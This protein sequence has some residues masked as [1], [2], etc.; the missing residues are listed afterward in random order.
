MRTILAA[1]VAVL[2]AMTPVMAQDD[3]YTEAEYV[4]AMRFAMG[5]A[6]YSV[7]HEVGHMMVGE[8]ALPVLGKEED[9][10]DSLAVILLLNDDEDENSYQS[11]VDAAD[12]W[13][14]AAQKTAISGMADLSFY[15]EHSLGIQ[16]A[17][18]MACL[19]IG[20]DQEWFK[21]T[22]DFYA[23]DQDRRDSCAYTYE[24]SLAAWNTVLEPHLTT[25]KP[26]AAID[27]IYDDA[28]PYQEFADAL[29]ER[30]ILEHA[31]ELITET[32]NLPRPIV[33]RA[34]QCGEANAYWSPSGELTY[35]YEMAEAMYNLYLSDVVYVYRDGEAG[36]NI[37]DQ[38]EAE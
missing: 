29:E 34:T 36:G 21:D 4:D 26:S 30:Q 23:I 16:R 20:K 31:A 6:V 28:G 32:Y 12:G 37:E 19:M 13:Y 33:F 7:Y 8:F 1:F 27:V 24:Q 35:C 25:G 14:F 9:A 10:A 17:Y 2:C 3:V 22:A 18:A 11:L 5:D 38:E 15:D